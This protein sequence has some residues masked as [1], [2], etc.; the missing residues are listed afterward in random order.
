MLFVAAAG[1]AGCGPPTPVDLAKPVPD[2]AGPLV[3]VTQVFDGDTVVAGPDHATVRLIGL[4]APERDQPY[5]AEARDHLKALLSEHEVRLDHDVEARD[6]YGRTLAYLYRD[7]GMLVNLEM[8][9]DGFAQALT[10]PPNV[11]HADA[12]RAAEAQARDAGRGLWQPSSLALAVTDLRPNPPGPDEDDLN[13]EWVQIIN[14]GSAAVD[15][16]GVTLSDEGN[17]TYAFPT[18]QIPRGTSVRLLTGSGPDRDHDLHWG[19]RVPI[20]NNGGDT[21]FLRDA[22]GRIVDTYHYG[23]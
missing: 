23:P 8:V 20:W 2:D 22:E 13:G 1:I 16:A 14:T 9:R 21:A 18:L 17:T 10:V 12:F 19:S 15:L 4:N 3:A 6:R 7:D 5:Y 11:A